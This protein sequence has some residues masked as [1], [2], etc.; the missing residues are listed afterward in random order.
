MVTCKRTSQRKQAQWAKRGKMVTLDRRLV[1]NV[2]VFK[3]LT[4]HCWIYK[5]G[6]YILK[7]KHGHSLFTLQMKT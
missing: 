6:I 4:C 1:H 7:M 5:R 2:L 3:R